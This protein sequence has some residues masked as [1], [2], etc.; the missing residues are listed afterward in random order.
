MVHIK[1]LKLNISIS[2]SYFYRKE[3]SFVVNSRSVYEEHIVSK[4][5]NACKLA[6][7]ILCPSLKF[8]SPTS[9]PFLLLSFGLSVRQQSVGPFSLQYI[10]L[11]STGRESGTLGKRSPH[12]TGSCW[13][14][15][16]SHLGKLP[17]TGGGVC[18]SVKDHV[19]MTHFH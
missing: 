13:S 15:V 3:I 9:H 7:F 11:I 18:A 5:S 1:N 17:A 2:T 12:G 10:S 4:S 14:A 16:I 6:K 8:Y 19:E